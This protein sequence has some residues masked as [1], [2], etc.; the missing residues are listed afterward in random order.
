MSEPVMGWCDYCLE[1]KP[2][3]TVIPADGWMLQKGAKIC[4]QCSQAIAA[5]LDRKW[6]EE[7]PG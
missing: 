7:Y 4:E 5:E 1:P 6:R 3:V 2:D